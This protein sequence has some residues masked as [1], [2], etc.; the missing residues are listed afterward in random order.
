[1]D[2]PQLN[3]VLAADY[4][5]HSMVLTTIKSVLYHHRNVQFYLINQDYPDEWFT[6][7]NKRIRNL[8]SVIHN[9]NTSE[10]RFNHYK[11]YHHISAA[12]FYRYFIPELIKEDKVLYLDCDLVVNGNLRHFYQVDMGDVAVVAA[13]DEIA[14]FFYGDFHFNAG[15]LLINNRVWRAANVCQRAFEIHEQYGN[16][17]RDADQSV[18]NILFQ[19]SWLRV[20]REF[21]YLVGWDRLAQQVGAIERVEK[22]A[23]TPAIIHYN[24]DVK[25]WSKRGFPFL[26]EYY[27]FYHHLSFEDIYLH[28]QQVKAA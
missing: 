18:L 13:K 1:M 6:G 7:V 15:V 14:E 5:Y 28:H 24:T 10:Q 19:N 27:W 16:A 12:T 25:P 3:I 26:R 2:T 23:Y 21:N 8:D 4:A 22:L 20:S 17:L 11:T 9:T